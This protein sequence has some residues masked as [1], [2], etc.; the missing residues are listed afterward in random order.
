MQ[1]AESLLKSTRSSGFYSLP[2]CKKILSVMV[3]SSSVS[4]SLSSIKQPLLDETAD[5]SSSSYQTGAEIRRQFKR[6]VE[7]SRLAATANMSPINNGCA[8]TSDVEDRQGVTS[9]DTSLF[10][11][12]MYKI[13]K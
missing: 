3:D 6:R 8:N 1:A 4:T 5:S 12:Y 9:Y 13:Q 7:K 10:L 11:Q 2:H